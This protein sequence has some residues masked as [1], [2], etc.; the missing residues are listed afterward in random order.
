MSL[1]ERL[2]YNILT[3]ESVQSTICDHLFCVIQ[4][5]SKIKILSKDTR[6]KDWWLGELQGKVSTVCSVSDRDDV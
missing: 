4:T 5:H 1:I 3:S 6:K 2:Y